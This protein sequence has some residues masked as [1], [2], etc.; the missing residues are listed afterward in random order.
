[1]RRNLRIE[2]DYPHPPS[3]VWRALTEPALL[4]AWLMKNDFRAERGHR[5]TMKTDPA[6]G[7]D[8]IVRCEVLDIDP[9]RSM[10][11][12]WRGGQLDTEVRFVLE[13]RIVFAREGTH[14][15]LEHQG[16]QGMPAVLVS[17][18]MQAGWRKMWRTKIPALLD[19]LASGDAIEPPR[20]AMKHD[21]GAWWWLARL[22][23]PILRRQ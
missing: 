19:R 1:M 23:A 9:P 17:F 10:R 8:G 2:R 20:A 16:F 21:R 18:I 3:L 6:P 13:P 12:S 11:W 5:F 14:L 22:F 15:I 4:E 7:F